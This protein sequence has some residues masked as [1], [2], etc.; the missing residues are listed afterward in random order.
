M[1][2]DG[3][4]QKVL[5]PNKSKLSGEGYTVLELPALF[6][7]QNKTHHKALAPNPVNF[8]YWQETAYLP[9]P[10]GP[11]GAT[12]KDLF[13]EEYEDKLD[14]Y[15]VSYVPTW[16]D[17]PSKLNYHAQEGEVHCGTSVIRNVGSFEWWKNLPA[18]G[19]N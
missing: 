18:G 5:S 1:D 13:A 9:K 12:G 11:V 19:S 4:T 2:A 7:S 14:G 10:Y 17:S 3:L 6:Y 15:S 8:Q 16:P